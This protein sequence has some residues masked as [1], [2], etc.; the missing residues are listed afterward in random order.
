MIRKRNLDPNTNGRKENVK[1]ELKAQYEIK[2]AGVL[3]G[4]V[5]IVFYTKI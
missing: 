1:E 4:I 2:D 3:D 5:K